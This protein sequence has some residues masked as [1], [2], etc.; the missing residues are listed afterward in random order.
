MCQQDYL[1]NIMLYCSFLIR[2]YLDP[3]YRL[4]Q[5]VSF[6]MNHHSGG[7]YGNRLEQLSLLLR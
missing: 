6:D 1:I 7:C 4:S 2:L 5:Q 3:R